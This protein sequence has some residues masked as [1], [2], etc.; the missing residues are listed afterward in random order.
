[1]SKKLVIKSDD[2][3]LK[4]SDYCGAILDDKSIGDLIKENLPA[5]LETYTN[6]PVRFKIELEFIG[7]SGLQVETQGYTVPAVEENEEDEDE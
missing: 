2:S 5:D 4:V 7:T 3:V 1:M 6:Y